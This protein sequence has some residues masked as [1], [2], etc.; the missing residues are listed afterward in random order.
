MLVDAVPAA[1]ALTTTIAPQAAATA[2]VLLGVSPTAAAHIA[3][4]SAARSPTAGVTVSVPAH[5]LALGLEDAAAPVGMPRHEAPLATEGL[6]GSE[7][8]PPL[9]ARTRGEGNGS[10]SLP[11]VD[12][13]AQPADCVLA[14]RGTLGDNDVHAS[15]SATCDIRLGQPPSPVSYLHRNLPEPGPPS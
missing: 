13:D 14:G 5:A 9:L 8:P 12:P 3:S 11:R 1:T 6:R 2:I 15:A 10:G 7:S 4:L